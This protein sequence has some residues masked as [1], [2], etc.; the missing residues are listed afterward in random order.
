V[1]D[2]AGVREAMRFIAAARSD[3]GLRHALDRL[4]PYGGLPPLLDTAS[5]LGFSFS[6]DELRQAHRHDWGLRRMH[7]AGEADRAASTVA[8]VNTPASRT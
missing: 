2:G 7:Y 8:V 4:D 6:E 3:P 1:S 5:G